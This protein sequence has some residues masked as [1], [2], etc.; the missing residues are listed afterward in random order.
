M[1]ILMRYL[2]RYCTGTQIK[3]AFF[4][5]GISPKICPNYTAH[6]NSTARTFSRFPHTQT[7]NMNARCHNSVLVLIVWFPKKRAI[8]YQPICLQ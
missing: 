6:A 5:Y 8:Y 3:Q 7:K 2:I 4:W 1:C